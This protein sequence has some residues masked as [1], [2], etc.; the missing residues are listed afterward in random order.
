MRYSENYE[1]NLVEGS[2]IVNPLVQDVP[3]YEA[4]DAAMFDNKEHSVGVATELKTGTVHAL[5]RQNEDAA[6]FRFTATSDY[7]VG[8]TFEVDG[9]QVSA[10][11]V[12]GTALPN[13]CYIIG[14]EVLASLKGTLLTVYANRTTAS[15][16]DKLGGQLPAYYATDADLDRLEGVVD[17]HTNQ[18]SQINSNKANAFSLLKFN[19]E[20]NINLPSNV[21]T[22]IFA[23]ALSSSGIG[24]I[25]SQINVNVTGNTRVTVYI[26]VYNSNNQIVD[27]EVYTVDIST[28]EII[29]VLGII[30]VTNGNTVHLNVASSTPATVLASGTDIRMMAN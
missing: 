1:L 26:N 5:T 14:S 16:S 30:N 8:D 27:Q 24:I 28:S 23:F 3:N 22:D 9:V 21:G 17:A 19:L 20:N 2:D 29:E 12:D 7:T 11:L 25:K 13:R 18:I 10:L 4:I 6:V 15:D